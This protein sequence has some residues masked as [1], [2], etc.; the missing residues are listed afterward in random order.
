MSEEQKHKIDDRL[1]RK[2]KKNLKFFHVLFVGISLGSLTGILSLNLVPDRNMGLLAAASVLLENIFIWTISLAILTGITFSFFAGRGIIKST[3]IIWKWIGSITILILYMF[4]MSPYAAGI[5]ASLDV[6]G[7]ISGVNGSQVS[8]LIISVLVTCGV[9]LFL[10]YISFVKPWGHRS[11]DP[12]TESAKIRLSFFSL[13]AVLTLYTSYMLYYF[14]NI[15]SQQFTNRSWMTEAGD[16]KGSIDCAGSRYDI[17]IHV[18]SDGKR[19]IAIESNHDSIYFTFASLLKYRLEDSD[20]FPVDTV[21]GATTTSI[22]ILRA[23]DTTFQ[24]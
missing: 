14:H 1:S 7:K 15:R 16:Y 8:G 9:M 19:D 2:W 17:Q 23:V 5:A 12:I 3:W 4:F 20:N 13:A 18:D 21:S 22:C 10:F 11:K 24:Q 6:S